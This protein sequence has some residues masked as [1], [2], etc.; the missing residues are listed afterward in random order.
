MI[1]TFL[2]SL[3]LL[4]TV[5]SDDS[6]GAIGLKTY[7]ALG[8]I[9]ELHTGIQTRQFSSF[10]RKGGNDDG[11]PYACL[12]KTKGN[13]CVIAEWS[14]PGELVS[15]WSTRDDGIVSKTGRIVIELDGSTVVS[16]SFE[17][18]ITHSKVLNRETYRFSYL[19]I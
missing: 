12:K 18:C 17:V 16:H 13:H 11:G 19:L 9:Q 1:L 15:I 3:L 7:N 14:G 2:I 8:Q 6:K 10:D 4:Q 5:T